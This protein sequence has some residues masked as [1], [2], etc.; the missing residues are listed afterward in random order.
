MVDELTTRYGNLLSGTYDC[1]DRIVL[2]A[3]FGVGHNP[4]GFRV[5]WRELYGNDDK[6][7]NAHLMRL[8]G[9]FSRRVRA[10][11]NSAGVPLLDCKAGERKHLIAEQYLAARNSARPGVFL[12][13]VARASVPVWDVQRSKRGVICNLAKKKAFVNHYSFHIVDPDWGHVTIKMSGHPPFDAQVM[14]N[15]QRVRGRSSR[16]EGNSVRKGGELFHLGPQP[17]GPGHS[18]R[19]LV[20]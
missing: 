7:D 11:A 6:L 19:D 12:V 8:A 16:C 13:L 14:L 5:W 1:V 20:L 3:Y 4:G 10:W 9:R 18:R 17:A 2:N 15:G